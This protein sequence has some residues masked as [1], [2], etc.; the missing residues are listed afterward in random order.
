MVYVECVCCV[1]GELLCGGVYVLFVEF[2]GG[3]WVGVLVGLF[4]W[5]GWCLVEV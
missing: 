2:G 5:D 1:D 4:C 3:F